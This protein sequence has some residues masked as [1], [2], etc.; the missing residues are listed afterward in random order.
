MDFVL[1]LY[2]LALILFYYEPQ[3]LVPIL[4]NV[5]VY[6]LLW[7]A[8]WVIIGGLGGLFALSALFLAFCLLYAPVYLLGNARRILDSQAWVDHREVR[9]YLGCS[10]LL[11]GLVTLAILHP[12]AAV[13][14]FA[15]LAGFAHILLRFLV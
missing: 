15:L 3:V 2:S 5:L 12:Q 11:G 8:L 10:A 1:P 9:F 13:V 6:E 7:W 4:D 14:S